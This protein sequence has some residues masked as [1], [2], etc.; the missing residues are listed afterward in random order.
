MRVLHVTTEYPPMVYGGLGTAVGGLVTASRRAGIEVAVVDPAPYSDTTAPV[1]SIPHDRAI[2]SAVRF[3]EL[4][5]PDVIH[6]HVFWLAHVAIGIRAATGTPLVYTVHSID[7]AEYE[8]GSGPPECLTQAS[9]SERPH[10][11]E[12][13]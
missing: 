7:R 2:E 9:G 13:A 4:W 3:A 8:I 5:R 10:T 11:A 6:V 1:V 12:S